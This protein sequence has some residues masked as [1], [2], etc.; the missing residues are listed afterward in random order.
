MEQGHVNWKDPYPASTITSNLIESEEDNICPTIATDSGICYVF[1][2]FS[3][4]KI[5]KVTKILYHF[6]YKLIDSTS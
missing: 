5:Y 6:C 1:N 2:G 4:T 3:P